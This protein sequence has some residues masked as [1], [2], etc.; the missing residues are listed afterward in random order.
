MVINEIS[1]SQIEGYLAQIET[2]SSNSETSDEFEISDPRLKTQKY[3]IDRMFS[4]RK[5][6]D[7]GLP[8]IEKRDPVDIVEISDEAKRLYLSAEQYRRESVE[9]SV[10]TPDGGKIN[11]RFE[12]ESS[13]RIELS[14][15][16]KQQQ[17][18]SQDPLVLDLNGNGV[19]LSDLRRGEG[20]SF[21][22]TGDGVEERVAWVRPDDGF[23][24]YDRN[25]NGTIDSGAELFGDQHGAANGFEELSKHDDDGNGQIDA[26]D[27]IFNDLRVWRDMNQNGRSER[28]EL[29]GLRSLGIASIRLSSVNVHE[30][31]AGNAIG[32][33][34]S[35]QTAHA[36]GSV[37]ETFLNYF[38]MG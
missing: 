34:G 2:A 14:A 31:I 35:Y 38:A 5:E 21:D 32:A 18:Q 20:V 8:P 4:D 6:K 30:V 29:A 33:Y 12:Q 26:A 13:A 15:D 36:A 11:L 37:A 25:A 23:L 3:L 28:N 24:A 17:I 1:P 9:L 22:I 16:Q 7:T 10:K 19:E 27:N